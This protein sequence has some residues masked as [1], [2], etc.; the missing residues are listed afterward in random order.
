MFAKRTGWNLE[1]NPLSQVL[2]RVRSD[3]K[4]V[5]DLTVS[6]PTACGFDY[7]SEAI[8][9]SLGNPEA[10]RYEPDPRGIESARN[11]VAAYYAEH[12]VHV[13]VESMILT[14]GTSEA[15]RFAIRLL[16]E[17]GDE[18]LVPEPSYPL[19]GFLAGIEDATLVPYP[20]VYQGVW[21]I[22]FSAIE[23]ALTTRARALVVVH[24][25]NPTGNYCRPEDAQRLSRLCAER[26]MAIVADEVFLDFA[27]NGPVPASFAGHEQALTFTLSGLSKIAGLPQMKTGWMVVNGPERIRREALERLEVIADTFLSMNTPIQLALPAL[28]DLRNGFQRQLLSRVRRNLAELDRQLAGQKSWRRLPVEGGWYV[29]LGSEGNRTDEEL[30]IELLIGKGVYLHPGHF[31]D[32][33]EE[34]YLV[35]S[36]IG[37]EAEFSDGIRRL[38]PQT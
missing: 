29:V 7:D 17:P 2:A 10:L 27:L 13:P 23:R 28:L 9:K 3:G 12:G 1:P 26:G 38:L 16:C 32:F 31:Y 5:L 20:L 22:D 25:N 35:A 36:L 37:P 4:K 34:G 19:L 11:A 6:N 18:V 24:P 30:A 33:A 15:Y 21:R 8:L 14:T